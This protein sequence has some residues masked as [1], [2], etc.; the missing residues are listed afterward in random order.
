M[1]GQGD[2]AE[3]LTGWLRSITSPFLQEDDFIFLEIGVVELVNNIIEHAF[4]HASGSITVTCTPNRS[5]VTL[6]FSDA[7]AA[8]PTGLQD[9]YENLTDEVDLEATSGRGLGLIRK[10]FEQVIFHRADG[11]NKVSAVYRKMQDKIEEF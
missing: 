6:D 10:C 1:D 11:L 3:R 5:Y 8:M 2:F 4:A 7:G 9:I